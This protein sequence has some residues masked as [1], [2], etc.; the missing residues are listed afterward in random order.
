[1]QPARCSD[2]IA[3]KCGQPEMYTLRTLYSDASIGQSI[4]TMETYFFDH[5]MATLDSS[6]AEVLLV[7]PP[8]ETGHIATT[9]NMLC[10]KTAQIHTVLCIWT[11]HRIRHAG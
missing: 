1:M 10:T 5:H 4:A 8:T 9:D 6:C 2:L 7:P 3:L 11:T